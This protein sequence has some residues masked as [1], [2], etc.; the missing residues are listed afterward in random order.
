M[1]KSS[2]FVFALQITLGIVFVFSGITKLININSFAE[3]L[4]NFKLLSD[5]LINI[6]KYAI[7]ILEILLVP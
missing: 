6:V 1:L 3:A 4:V 2:R 7:P 5:N